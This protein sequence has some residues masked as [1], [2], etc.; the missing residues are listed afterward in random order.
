MEYVVAVFTTLVYAIFSI[1]VGKSLGLFIAA[2]FHVIIDVI[3]LP[4]VGLYVIGIAIVEIIIG[5]VF[6]MKKIKG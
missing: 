1:Y 2:V 3:S 5:V 6:V 4:S